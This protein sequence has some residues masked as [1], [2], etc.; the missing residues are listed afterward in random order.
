LG[1]VLLGGGVL[2]LV[3]ELLSPG[4]LPDIGGTSLSIVALGAG[5]ILIWV[6]DRVSHRRQWRSF[7]RRQKK[8]YD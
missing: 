6:A 3:L 5:I 1:V 8:Y 2:W 4:L 7:D